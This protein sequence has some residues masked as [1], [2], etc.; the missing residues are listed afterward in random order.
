MLHQYHRLHIFF[1]YLQ[2]AESSGFDPHNIKFPSHYKMDIYCFYAVIL[3]DWM[4]LYLLLWP[5][6]C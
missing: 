1:H 3:K 5:S 4:E 2:F 6:I